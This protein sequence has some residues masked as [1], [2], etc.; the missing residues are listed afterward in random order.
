[1]P[2]RIVLMRCGSANRLSPSEG[3]RGAPAPSKTMQFVLRWWANIK[4]WEV[5]E[6][7]GMRD[8]P[9]TVCY[10]EDGADDG[11]EARTK[12]AEEEAA[13]AAG[14]I[15]PPGHHGEVASVAEAH[16]GAGPSE[17]GGRRTKG[18]ACVCNQ[19]TVRVG[20]NAGTPIRG[21]ERFMTMRACSVHGWFSC[22]EG[23]LKFP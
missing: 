4:A 5:V 22:R 20:Q 7:S 19:R 9:H 1:M 6:K 15:A 14:A 10:V 2:L 11:T 21:A 12:L 8:G 13:A 18:P 17:F 3:E 16:E 23:P